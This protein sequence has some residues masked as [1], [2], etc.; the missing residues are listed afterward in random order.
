MVVWWVILWASIQITID[1][2]VENGWMRY[3]ETTEEMR[4]KS[5]VMFFAVSA[6]PIVRLLVTM[7]LFYMAMVSN[8]ESS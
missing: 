5:R 3:G 1:K 6:V 2:I 7:S 4:K 8:D